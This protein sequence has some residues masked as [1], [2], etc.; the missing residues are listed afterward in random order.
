[1][2]DVADLVALEHVVRVPVRTKPKQN[3]FLE[4]ADHGAAAN[5]VA[6]VGFRIVHDHR[7]RFLQQRHLG[8]A[9]VDA[10]D[11]E[12]LLAEDAVFKQALDNAL[13]V[14]FQR[15]D[16]IAGAF[17][18]V[19]V[20]P[21]GSGG[22]LLAERERFIR[23]GERGVQTHHAL[24]HVAA[25]R[26]CALHHARVLQNRLLHLIRAVAVG[27]LVA[28][29]RANAELARRVSNGIEAAGDVV[30]TCVMVKH[31]G[32]AV[33]DAIDVD[34]VGGEAIVLLGQEPVDLPPHTL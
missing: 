13:A 28:E 6:H 20:E 25:V 10:M 29:A 15:V 33:L 22:M 5:R 9:D 2:D 14:L 7:I 3:P 18:N 24:E 8:G 30:I 1:M 23:E 34:G 21:V 11:R 12:R 16:L 27:N 19:N 26:V 17:R 4:Q 31:R 32:H